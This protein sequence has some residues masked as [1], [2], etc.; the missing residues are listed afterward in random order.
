MSCG[1]CRARCARDKVGHAYLL[2]GPRG[3]GKTSTARVL[4]K[5][6]NC[7]DLGS[8][9]EPCCVCESCLSIQHGRSF[10]LQELDAASNNKVDDMRALLERVNLT[11]PGRAK[12]YLL[13]EVHMLTAGAENALLKTLEEP[14]SHVTWVLA[15][16]EPHKVVQTIR[17]RCQVFELGLIPSDIM[18]DH[19]RYVVH[20]RRAGRGRR[21]HRPCRGRGRRL[22]ARHAH[23]PRAGGGRRRDNRPR[24]FDRRNAWGSG[25]R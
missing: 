20:R 4:A 25:R 9:G 2:H 6:L 19:I 7:T 14:P 24:L 5:A 23:R 22:G 8:D 15:T 18:S 11:S 1:P 10:D 12:V 3:S 13:D 21:S 17:S 16:T